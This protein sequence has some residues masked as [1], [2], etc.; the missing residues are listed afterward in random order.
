MFNMKKYLETID[1]VY[2]ILGD[3]TPSMTIG[4]QKA[5]LYVNVRGLAGSEL[6]NLVENVNVRGIFPT[7]ENEM[8]LQI[9]IEEDYE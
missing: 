9:D 3:K 6:R 7:D 8:S 1:L 2:G 5:T 4:S